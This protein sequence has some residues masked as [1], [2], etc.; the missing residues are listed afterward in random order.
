MGMTLAQIEQIDREYLTVEEVA[1]YFGAKP[2]NIR[3]QAHRNREDLG[4]PVSI[5]GSRVK[6]PKVGFINFIKGASA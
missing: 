3:V 4:F 5:I 2:Q 1:A 6:I